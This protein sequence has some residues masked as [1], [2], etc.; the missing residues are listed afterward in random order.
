[1]LLYTPSD[2]EDGPIEYVAAT[3]HEAEAVLRRADLVLNFHHAIDP[4]LLARVRRTAFVDIDPGLTQLWISTGQLRVPPHDVYFTIGE[5]VGTATAGGWPMPARSRGA[6]SATRPTSRARAASGAARS[7][8]SSGY[9]T[10]GSAIA[11][12]AIWRAGSPWS[13]SIPGRAFTSPMARACSDSRRSTKR[14]RPSTPSTAI[15]S[16][17]AAPPERSP[18]PTSTPGR[19]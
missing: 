14:R 12:S 18:R 4:C 7:R 5:T 6:S 8:S 15:T 10:P 2:G 11:R 19:S 1:V 13:S 9:E 17:S 16:G 3:R